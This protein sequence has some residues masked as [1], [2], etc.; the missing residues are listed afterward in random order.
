MRIA[1]I[2]IE[3]HEYLF[4]EAQ[5][6][7]FGG[8]YLYT[9]SKI[10]DDGIVVSRKRND[11]FIEGLFQ[12]TDTES[13]I[14]QL[15]AIVGQNGAGKSTIID[16]MRSVFIDHKYAL[17]QSKSLFL[18]ESK[19]D[20]I[21]LVLRNDFGK[22]ILIENGNKSE[23]NLGSHLSLQSIYY[24][25]HFNYN[26][27]RNFDDFDDHDISFD[28]IL[29][30]DLKP[31]TE[32][33]YEGD[34]A[35]FSPSQELLFKNTVRQ[36]EFLNSE[37]I[38]EKEVFKSIFQLPEL[39]DP[40]LEFRGIKDKEEH[41]NTPGEYR[42]FISLIKQKV[43]NELDDWNE[44][45]DELEM[46]KYLL[47]RYIIKFTIVL[48]HRYIE[49]SNNY[50]HEGDVPDIDLAEH[51][52]TDAYSLLLLFIEHFSISGN[53]VFQNGGIESLLSKLYQL[54]DDTESV[55][56]IAVNPE[57]TLRVSKED[58]IQLLKLQKSFES[59]LSNYFYLLRQDKDEAVLEEYDRVHGFIHYQPFTKK[60]SSGEHALL[61]LFSRLYNFLNSNLKKDRFRKLEDHYILLLD[62]ADLSFH[63]T[64][65]KKY[66]KSLLTT[67]P[68]FFEE[69][70]NKPS[71]Q[72]IFTTHDPLSLSDL[73]NDN[74]VYLERPS[75]DE[76]SQ[77]LDYEHKRRPDK[78]FGA[79]IVELLSDSFFIDESL[80]GEFATDLIKSTIEWLNEEDNNTN[81]EYYKKVIGLID[82]PIV[83][84]KLAEMY[85]DKMGTTTKREFIDAEIKR[86]EALKEKLDN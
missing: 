8:E 66:V 35:Y 71:I 7:N 75:Y 68:Y 57:Q 45:E 2:Y 30:L 16:V 47:K 9:F 76:K 62:E 52:D 10:E 77:V 78:T 60:L 55:N 73:P 31:L 53:K 84:R 20:K 33:N 70:E 58:A 18:V 27:N 59:E 80:T 37:L 13:K 29:E 36:I 81:S 32:G 85:D 74:V 24:S 5:T 40:L 65:K 15:N 22:I 51:Q 6:I 72:I 83:K 61:N 42:E 64:W 39:D 21:P 48:I 82:E 4:D 26:F 69:L 11:K 23:L 49:R 17:P 25:P 38:V 86:L 12:L 28:K 1:A 50:L 46:K 34:V 63:P 19:S 43:E 54:I 41:W 79:N 44:I 3:D 67:L 56:Q 14:T